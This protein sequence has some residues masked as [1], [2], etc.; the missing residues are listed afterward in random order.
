MGETDDF[1]WDDEKDAINRAKHGLP[2]LIAALLFDGQ[3]RLERRSPKS[4]ADEPRFETMGM[5][6]GRVLFCVW[7]WR[8]NRRRV[9]SLRIAKRKERHAYQEAVGGSGEARP[10]GRLG[11]D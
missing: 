6:Q 9:M 11:E 10:V 4:P 5:V 3:P 8:G 1:E 2:L 7:T